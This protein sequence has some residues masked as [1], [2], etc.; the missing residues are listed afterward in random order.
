MSRCSIISFRFGP[1]DGVSVVARNWADALHQMG[2]DV[3]WVAGG[4]EQGWH[5]TG[6]TTVVPGLGIDDIDRPTV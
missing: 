5:A 4:F 1:T 6:A 3:D 2:F